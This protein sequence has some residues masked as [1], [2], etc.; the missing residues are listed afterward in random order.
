MS[1]FKDLLGVIPADARGQMPQ[2]LRDLLDARGDSVMAVHATAGFVEA[3]I[4][5]RLGI[6]G[7]KAV[8]LIDKDVFFEDEGG[9]RLGAFIQAIPMTVHTTLN[10][11]MSE[12]MEECADEG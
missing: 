9:A 11:M 12:H 7:I 4:E 3:G 5:V 8:I 2:E 6:K 10:H 1:D